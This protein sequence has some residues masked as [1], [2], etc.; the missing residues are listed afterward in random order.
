MAEGNRP[1]ETIEEFR[2]SGRLKNCAGPD[3]T[4]RKKNPND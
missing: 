1:A 3:K 4:R 2:F